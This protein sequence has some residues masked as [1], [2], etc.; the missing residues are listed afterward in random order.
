MAGLLSP[1]ITKDYKIAPAAT[2]GD[3]SA[4][5][6]KAFQKDIKA[7]E[8]FKQF[9]KQYGEDPDLNSPDYNYRAAW[10]A[11]VKPELYKFDNSYHWPSVSPQGQSLKA[12]SHPTAWME[13]YMAI[14][15]RDPHE[16]GTMSQ[17]QIDAVQRA[18]MFRYGGLLGK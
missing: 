8:W 14:T 10:K 3:W 11:G 5:D 1:Q 13:D 6:E 18:L 2:I 16:A 17:D 12:V 15:G 7:T 4:K 9:K